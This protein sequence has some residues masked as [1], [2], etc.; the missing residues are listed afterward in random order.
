MVTRTAGSCGD[1]L[2]RAR[3]HDVGARAEKLHAVLR[4][5]QLTRPP[6]LTAA[7]ATTISAQ[8]AIVTTLNA[9]ITV[10]EEQVEAH[11]GQHPD[12]EILL[13]YRRG[14]LL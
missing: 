13:M 8:V 6:V 10:M 3:R 2:K 9:Q 5:P 11:V 1:P 7:H 14:P 12:A 4:A